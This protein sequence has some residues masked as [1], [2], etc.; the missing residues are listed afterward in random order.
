[1]E[2]TIKLQNNAGNIG[3]IIS[4]LP[5]RKASGLKMKISCFWRLLDLRGENGQ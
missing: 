4:I 2:G 5:K 3:S 1:V